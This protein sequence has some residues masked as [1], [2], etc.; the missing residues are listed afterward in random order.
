MSHARYELDV[1]V[2]CL[3]SAW[4]VVPQMLLFAV[5]CVVT[6]MAIRFCAK[7]NSLSESADSAVE[8]S[9]DKRALAEPRR[10]NWFVIAIRQVGV[11]VLLA[12][13]AKY[14]QLPTSATAT[15]ATGILTAFSRTID[16]R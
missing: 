1:H 9:L 10:V 5:T 6:L 13:P 8:N 15:C 14:A 7:I 12:L 16:D 11:G 4:L 3:I 2:W